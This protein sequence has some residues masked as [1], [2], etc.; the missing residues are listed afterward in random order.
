MVRTKTHSRPNSSSSSSAS[1]SEEEDDDDVLVDQMTAQRGRGKNMIFGRGTQPPPSENSTM[2]SDDVTSGKGGTSKATNSAAAAARAGVFDALRV[3]MEFAEY[4]RGQTG[5]RV[6]R[7]PRNQAPDRTI[8]RRALQEADMMEMAIEVDEDDRND[9]ENKGRRKRL[10]GSK[11]GFDSAVLK[12]MPALPNMGKGEENAENGARVA[13]SKEGGG[14]GEALNEDIDERYEVLQEVAALGIDLGL[15][16]IDK[17]DD[18]YEEGG[19]ENGSIDDVISS[20]SEYD[21]SGD[22]EDEKAKRKSQTISNE[23]ANVSVSADGLVKPKKRLMHRLR[24]F[25][26]IRLAEKHGEAIGAHIRGASETAVQK[27]R[28]VC[29]VLSPRFSFVVFN[30]TPVPNFAF[31]FPRRLQGRLPEPLKFT[32]V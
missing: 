7:V 19:E 8:K 25:T 3:E 23:R 18:D 4:A 10:R 31:D 5:Q 9:G 22:E 28:E 32:Q 24:E 13:G 15:D 27:L 17:L 14:S 11:V 1:S 29:R 16:E 21:E 6:K 12:S 26:S 20:S 2:A 30:S